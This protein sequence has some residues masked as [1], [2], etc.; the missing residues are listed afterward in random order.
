MRSHINVN[1]SNRISWLISFGTTTPSV[2]HVF[3][4]RSMWPLATPVSRTDGQPTVGLLYEYVAGLQHSR[5]I[6]PPRSLHPL[7]RSSAKYRSRIVPPTPHHRTIRVISVH[8]PIPPR[9]FYRKLDVLLRPARIV[10]HHPPNAPK[11]ASQSP[12]TTRSHKHW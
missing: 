9:S 6:I 2:S 10:G 11:F 3:P 1:L 5:M 8:E 12:E 7:R 4:S